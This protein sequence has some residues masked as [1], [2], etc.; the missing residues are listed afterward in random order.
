MSS[1]ALQDQVIIIT[2]GSRGIGRHLVL[3]AVQQ[4]ARV[5]YCARS[6]EGVAR[7][8]DMEAPGLHSDG[9]VLAIRADISQERDVEE[10]FARTLDVFGRVD[11]V[12]NNAGISRA[13]ALFHLPTQ[14]WDDVMAV[15]LT[16]VFLVSR[17]AVR[18][19]LTQDQGGRIISMGSIAQYGAP[20]NCAY[21]ASKGG[22]VGLTQSIAWEYGHL[23]IYAYLV[24]GGYVRTELI[25]DVPES[26]LALLTRLCP[27]KRHAS[28]D[29]IAAAVL[30]LASNPGLQLNGRSIHVTGGLI[31]APAYA[32]G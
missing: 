17:E 20:V 8:V 28:G 27:Q 4:G 15:N 5:V 1:G 22:L 18:T 24:I 7:A 12:V 29:E 19:F 26:F 11:V 30:H 13:R 10:L 6:L 14:D 3:N 32:A 31:E 23:G 2:G 21:A 25:Q 9:Q 16:G